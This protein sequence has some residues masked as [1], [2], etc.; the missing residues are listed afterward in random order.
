MTRTILNRR[1]SRTG[2]SILAMATVLA[3]GASPAFA[4]SFAG[5]GS[6]SSGTG[7]ITTSPN[8]TSISVTSPTAVINW[9]PTDNVANPNVPI[10]F[11]PGG[12]FADYSGGGNYAVLNRINVADASRVIQLD[13][14]IR[15][16]ASGAL[17]GTGSI[18]FYSPSGFLLGGTSVINVPSLVLSALPIVADGSGN[19]II[20][21]D[22]TV[23]F[24]PAASATASITAMPGSQITTNLTGS[25]VAMVAPRVAHHG[26][27]TNSGQTALVAAEAATINFSPDGLFDISVTTGTADAN[28]IALHGD[29]NGQ[30]STGVGDNNRI[31]AVAV[32]KNDALTMVIGSGAD[33][34]FAI[35]G[36]A[37]V[38]GN[39]IVLSAGH[40]VTDGVVN[41]LPTTAT[42]EAAM[43]INAP[44]ATSAVTAVASG[45]MQLFA[46]PGQVSTFASNVTLR[47]DNQVWAN[48]TGAGSLL[49]IAGNLTM[50]STETGVGNGAAGQGGFIALYA[51]PSGT[52]SVS[53]N[54][55]L[56]SYGYG[57]AS[58]SAGINGGTGTGGAI[59]VQSEGA[60]SLT[61]NGT[62]TATSAG[63]GGNVS[64]NGSNGGNG[65]GG[66]VLV[67]T[68]AANSI[69]SVGGATLAQ[70]LGT[71][72]SVTCGGC[73][74]TGGV[75]TGGS[76]R[77]N[78]AGS[79]SQINL[80]AATLNAAGQGGGGM[81][82]I[83]GLGQGGISEVA[84][85]NSGPSITINGSLNATAHGTGGQS[86][87]GGTG[88]G[89]TAA[90]IGAGNITVTAN[91]T[92]NASGF[93]GV[94][95]S[96]AG[97]DAYGGIGRLLSTG[98]TVT[99]GG[100]A[101][102]RTDATAETGG[103]GEGGSSAHVR[104]SNG[105]DIV[106]GMLNVTA[107]GRGGNDAGSGAGAG[108]GGSA[109]IQ[110]SGAGSTVTVN[111]T[112]VGG[113]LQD[114]EMLSADGFGGG[115]AVGG[116]TAGTGTGGTSELKALAGGAITL[117][118]SGADSLV[119]ARGFGGTP[120]AGG[121]T[122]G[123]GDGGYI[124]LRV[125]GG[126]LSGGKLQLSSYGLGGQA[127]SN[128][129]NSEGGD[130]IG[131]ERHVNVLNGGTLTIALS[132]GVAGGLGGW[133]TGTG[134]G[135]DGSGGLATLT[136]DN[137]TFNVTGNS[138]ITAQSA[139][140]ET[141]G[142]GNGGNATGGNT[143]T[144]SIINGATVNIAS[145][146]TLGLYT[147]GMGGFSPNGTG[148]NAAGGTINATIA[149]STV[150]GGTL[151]LNGSS[152][153]GNGSTGGGDASA[154]TT[155]LALSGAT[156]ATQMLRVSASATSGQSATGAAGDGT[157]GTAQINVNGG[158]NTITSPIEIL[159]SGSGG[160]ITGASG[161][162]GN[163]TG[164]SAILFLADGASLTANG[165]TL[166]D[167]N[168]V[169][170]SV[171]S[172]GTGGT[173]DGGV[174]SIDSDDA[175][176]TFNG[177]VTLQ[178]AAAGGNAPAGTGGSALGGST[179][180]G[181]AGGTLAIAGGLSMNSNA[182][183]GNGLT[184]GNARTGLVEVESR[185][186]VGDATQRGMLTANSLTATAV[187][188]GGSGDVSGTSTLT[189][190]SYFRLRNGDA[191][192]GS[193]SFTLAGSVSDLT[194][195]PSYVSV[196]DGGANIGSFSFDTDGVLTLDANNGSMTANSITLAAANFVAHPLLAAPTITGT[197]YAT[198][199][200]ITTG[201]NF[202]T[203]AH[204][205]SVNALSIVAPG[206]ITVRNV[207]GDSSVALNAQAGPLNFD[208]INAGG[209]VT[210]LSGTSISGQDATTDGDLLA[211]AF[212]GNIG[213]DDLTADGDIDL[214]ASGN[215]GIDTVLAGFFRADAGGTFTSNNI[216]SDSDI[217]IGTGGNVSLGDLVAGTSSIGSSKAVR[218]DTDGSVLVGDILAAG[219]IDITAVGSVTGNN[220]TT[221]DVLITEANGAITYANISAGLVNP[222][223]STEPVSVGLD[224]ATSISVGNVDAALSVAFITSGTLTAGDVTTGA[225]LLGFVH[226]NM[227]IGDIDANGRVLLADSSMFTDAGGTIG[228][229]GNDEIDIES[230][231][232]ATPVATGGTITVGTV[233]AGSFT[234]AAGTSLTVSNLAIDNGLSLDAGGALTTGDLVVGNFVLANGG[235]ISTG[236]IDADSV[237]ME[238]TGGNITI[239]G[240]VSANGLVELDAFGNIVTD[241]I[242]AGTIDLAAG[243]S[244]T[245]DNLTT[246][247]PLVLAAADFQGMPDVDPDGEGNIVVIAGGNIL[248]GDITAAE[249]ILL[250]TP[251][252]ITG[253]EIE[254]G[255]IFMALAHGDMVF[256]N[257]T[258]AEV[259]LADFAMYSPGGGG[260]VSAICNGVCGTLGA[261]GVITAPPSGSTYSYVT[262][263]GGPGGAGQL[264]GEGGINGSDYTTSAFSA[265]AGDDLEFWFNYVTSDGSGFADYA[266]A[267]LL[268][269]GLDPV[270]ILFTART[271]ASGTIVPGFDLP[272]VEATLD[273]ASV[274]IIDGGPAW[275]PL[276]GSSGGCYS[277]G[278]GY[279]GWVNSKYEIAEAGNYVLRFGVTNW[280][281]SGF[282][283]G[284]AFS[285]ITVGGVPVESG[286]LSTGGSITIG[287][288]NAGKMTAAAG[289]TLTTGIID[290]TDF[291]NLVSGGNMLTQGITAGNNLW[292]DAGGTMTLGVLAGGDIELDSVGNMSFVSGNSDTEF[293]F[294]SDG[295]VNG[296]NVTAG[297]QISGDAGGS[298]TLANLTVSGPP[299]EGESFSIGIT[300]LGNISVGNASG[301]G[302]VGF[303]TPEDLTTGNVTAGD[304]FLTLV[305]GD[306]AINGSITT[307]GEGSQVYMADYS[308]CETGGGCT[309]DG[310]GD[311]GDENDFDPSIVLGLEPVMTDGSIAITGPVSTGVFRAAAGTSFIANN[312]SAN[313]F[314]SNEEIFVE[315]INVRAGGLA[316]VNGTWSGPDVNVVSNDID[317]TGTGSINAGDVELYS[318]NATQTVVGDGVGGGG[319]QLSD[320]EFDRINVNGELEV[321]AWV[322][323]G[324]A[325]RMMFG[326][327]T[328]TDDSEGGIEIEFAVFEDDSEVG[329]G[330][331]R[332]VGDM[333][334]NG[335]SGD[336]SVHFTTG[337]FELDAATGSVSLFSGGT[338]L[339]GE[340]ALNA[341]RIHV[342]AGS[343]LDDLAE[344]PTYTGYQQD[345]NEA[346]DVQRPEGVLRADT[347]W[348]ESDNLQDILIQN[349]GSG[350]QGGVP[351]GFL[352]RQAFINDEVET[353]PGS[354]NLIING[355]VVTEGGTLTGVAARDELVGDSDTAGATSNSTI[356]GCP[357]TGVCVI[358]SE[359]PPPNP[360]VI[361]DQIDLINDNPLGDG[362][363]GNED[364]I[365]D[366]E[367]GDE[368]AENP[369]SPPQPLFDTRPLVP[370][371]DV[372]DPV[373]GTGNPAL[374]GS[375]SD[376]E[377]GEDRQCPAP[378]EQSDGDGK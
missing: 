218:I 97:G 54:A 114:T 226:G 272:G 46:N 315:G 336:D 305:G 83:G 209:N 120:L 73:T 325:D 289:T 134:S 137:A 235:S 207:Q 321:G 291:A 217:R 99:V 23:T 57:A 200:N 55:L 129:Y 373:S 196:R 275:S 240:D 149:N 13:G 146:A 326:D 293:D 66:E 58:S 27:I 138:G 45:N 213:L 274:P 327:L 287:N 222:Q 19:F 112:P 316:T 247:L 61:I 21:A 70:S 220:I 258:A 355:Q 156:I 334:F 60:S 376:C 358:K 136:V 212:G 28:G 357:L 34:G 360:D 341:D 199:F 362:D 243:G 118:T 278:C 290:V 342:A 89:G 251:G 161:T 225:D 267:S 348:I 49:S 76:A 81:L 77:I 351:A 24:G 359:E 228:D 268:T 264:P 126:T 253:E 206:S 319:Y 4:Q 221:G 75:G 72:G 339:G 106:V 236:S 69:L 88:R 301:A 139:G 18:Y 119:R 331:M 197:Y 5:T 102:V 135:G 32:P 330:S 144:A 168:G 210:L 195:G 52:V 349:T 185:D 84:I 41:A 378:V 265:A 215:I 141:L 160:N 37:N 276:G 130:G 322:G 346:A 127:S 110:A 184:G 108:K 187:A 80:A 249:S 44:R 365:D 48:A 201:N 239:G 124:D 62:L 50:T 147:G 194:F 343:I 204:L 90:M 270:A 241:N 35:A 86:A 252:T 227:A 175:S 107:D 304:L 314:F 294:H 266:W 320:A 123:V 150:N 158:S 30:A 132:G 283:S 302:P 152:F 232:T 170:G 8:T 230:L 180:I 104:A 364:S 16:V 324:A 238:S 171:A 329:D 256:G 116:A 231:F 1:R 96:G 94:G 356:N 254:A 361:D 92:M 285:G 377:E 281:D 85:L 309:D 312:I 109:L 317:I 284:M 64:V 2:C 179:Q 307:T 193:V 323:G 186:R 43:S 53:G 280:G 211:Q 68:L 224:S 208:N 192:I 223:P 277:A 282:D 347:L 262:T 36:A 91:A 105:G 300:A 237:S 122:G 47:G 142:A 306:I 233:D 59:W 352:V 190:G 17:T 101:R 31:Y 229:F 366:N 82:G 189:E 140:G 370:T 40:N 234:A 100:L 9:I 297:N 38:D 216:T 6:F 169:G 248:T 162:G 12:T 368:G 14:T 176:A 188:T 335:M 65:T 219:G 103:Y 353:P 95:T 3:V 263:A 328:Y 191:A 71:G 271:Q 131:G 128:A 153:G 367:E 311:D 87:A 115:T 125:D 354:V 177:N 313:G 117:P 182:T 111:A 183:G 308:M 67:R 246:E 26:T 244:I 242:T 245:T 286:L 159:A 11:Q 296:G 166:I 165:T 269:A 202:L 369:I 78:A 205:D 259:F 154:G 257:A 273:P 363:F 51:N 74:G 303:G 181:T 39:A 250:V 157:G 374:L 25:Y 121:T 10:V 344:N 173:G 145:G 371:G 167:A 20:G 333:V 172:A 33:L 261:D 42:S 332:V 292:A 178:A 260:E 255:D 133:G 151:E 318:T 63:Q 310:E 163:G 214:D 350:G 174:A 338:T 288:V 298:V 15:T 337:L 295:S 345:L 164:G 372:S 29:I 340:L 143:V 279:T 148:G 198:S 155:T 98:G 93:G 113:N 79:G 375:D 299:Q 22:R 203:N 56:E 7:S